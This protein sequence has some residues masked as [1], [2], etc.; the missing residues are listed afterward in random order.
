[1]IDSL[2]IRQQRR[3]SRR[4]GNRQGAVAVEFALALPILLAI[5]LGTTEF[6]LARLLQTSVNDAARNACEAAA[7]SGV[8][9]EVVHQIV[10]DSLTLDGYDTSKIRVEIQVNGVAA[11]TS[12]AKFGDL[13]TIHVS[14]SADAIPGTRFF[15]ALFDDGW[16]QSRATM[17]RL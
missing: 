3:P 7:A 15:S 13:L 6:T 2:K 5:A 1:M 16:I 4:R 9:D 11:T 17:M 10:E 14:I 12:T 8:E